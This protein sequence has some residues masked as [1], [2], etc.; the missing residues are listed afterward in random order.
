MNIN[1]ACGTDEHTMARRNFL[2]T[3]ATGASAMV[4]GLGCLI[5]SRR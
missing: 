5:L 4:G 1:Y 3:V 2:G